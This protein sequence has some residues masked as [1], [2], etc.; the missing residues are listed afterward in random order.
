MGS[1]AVEELASEAFDS[2]AFL[3][4]LMASHE[5]E[6]PSDLMWRLQQL[7]AEK[8][9]EFESAAK[10][11]KSVLGRL[12]GDWSRWHGDTNV[13]PVAL[14]GAFEAASG[15]LQERLGSCELGALQRLMALEHGRAQV[16]A[17]QRAAEEESRW[18]R[19]CSECETA[20]QEG[21]LDTAQSRLESMDRM[22]LHGDKRTARL[23]SLRQRFVALIRNL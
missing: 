14:K 12:E 19:L 4:Q 5:Q 20:L 22:A 13:G 23:E 21:D 3:S 10:H 15:S 16:L 7:E 11:L 8:A 17:L 9:T 2:Q 1:I 18:R 6:R